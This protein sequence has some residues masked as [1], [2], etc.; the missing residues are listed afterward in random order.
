MM[1]R[2]SAV[3]WFSEAE[4]EGLDLYPLTR[5]LLG[6]MNVLPESGAY[7]GALR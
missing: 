4:L 3:G 6:A 2:L 1:R 5:L 7:G